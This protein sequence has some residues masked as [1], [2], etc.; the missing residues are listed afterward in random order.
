MAVTYKKVLSFLLIPAMLFAGSGCSLINRGIK[1]I[2]K[3]F[4]DNYEK[5]LQEKA[6]EYG[7]DP[8]AAEVMQGAQYFKVYVDTPNSLEK[9]QELMITY[10]RWLRF[11]CCELKH[12]EFSMSFY[13]KEHKE[14][15]YGGF[16]DR[17]RGY[18]TEY[19][20]DD[21]Q[22]AMNLTDKIYILT[23]PDFKKNKQ[24]PEEF[25]KMTGISR[26][27]AEQ[28]RKW[29]FETYP[30]EKQEKPDKS[31]HDIT[32]IPGDTIN[33]RERFVI[34]EKD[35]PIGAGTYTV[36]FPNKRGVI[37]VTDAE[38]NF[39]YRIDGYYRDGHSDPLYQYSPVPAK[40][41][42]AQGDIFYIINCSATLDRVSE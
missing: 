25:Y 9:L 21:K 26:E 23:S 13:D 14:I 30:T 36:D 42:L 4:E 29:Y 38:G 6:G 3:G 40:M 41:E 33:H 39:K 18:N 1:A 16:T 20:Y 2:D 11:G 35:C 8:D 17:Y 32:F 22:I 10:R 24:T 15:C 5:V 28:Y 7:I 31:E 19:F 12:L 37:H 27:L 34:G